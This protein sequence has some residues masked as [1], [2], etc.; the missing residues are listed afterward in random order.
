MATTSYGVNHPMAVKLWRRKLFQEALKKCWLYRFMSKDDKAAIQIMDD[1]Q[2]GP[3]DKITIGLRMQLTAAGVL[4]DSTLEGNEEALTVYSDSLF[5][6][7]L[8]N[9]V[10]SDG[11]MSEQRIPFSIREQ[12][13]NGLADWWSDRINVSPLAA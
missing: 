7:Q 1:T 4:G 3:G 2:K 8:R 11:K 13:K 6:N 9:A 12:A 5:I 10:R